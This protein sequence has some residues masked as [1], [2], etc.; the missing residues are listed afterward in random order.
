MKL[1]AILGYAF[2][3][4]FAFGAG[5]LVYVLIFAPDSMQTDNDAL[6][7]AGGIMVFAMLAMAFCAIAEDARRKG[8]N[9][10]DWQ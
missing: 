1:S 7:C 4:T 6:F 2:A 10:A 3:Y 9:P 5:L 8:P